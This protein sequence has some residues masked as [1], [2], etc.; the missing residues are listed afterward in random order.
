MTQILL[1]AEVLQRLT[2]IAAVV[3]QADGGLAGQG[4]D[5]G[6][7]DDVGGV[8]ATRMKRL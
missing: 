2:D 7:E 4:G 8:S 5:G 3:D 6:I 1:A